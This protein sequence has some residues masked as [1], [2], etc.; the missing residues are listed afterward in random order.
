[1]V[2]D[3]SFTFI[4]DSKPVDI[5]QAATIIAH[6]G[7][8]REDVYFYC[9]KDLSQAIL[10]YVAFSTDVPDNERTF[11]KGY[12][13]LTSSP[14]EDVVALFEGDIPG[15]EA[16]NRFRGRAGQLEGNIYVH[17]ILT[18]KTFCASQKPCEKGSEKEHARAAAAEDTRSNGSNSVA[19][20]TDE[21]KA[22]TYNVLKDFFTGYM[23]AEKN[24]H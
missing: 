16:F 15:S 11:H 5:E 10:E 1:M 23:N 8:A 24:E 7:G 12:E 20:K 6:K 4:I 22:K 9:T 13:L 14:M 17:A 2:N 21:E 3:T 19:E 18:W